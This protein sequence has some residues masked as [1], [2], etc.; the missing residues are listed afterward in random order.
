MHNDNIR[1]A[2]KAI[3][4]TMVSLTACQSVWAGNTMPPAAPS[5]L[6]RPVNSAGDSVLSGSVTQTTL[7]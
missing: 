1:Q 6:K 5:R 4:L 7:S 3:A 2:V